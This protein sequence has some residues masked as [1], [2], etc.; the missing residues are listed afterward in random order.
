MH[1]RHPLGLTWLLSVLVLAACA[2]GSGSSGFD[3][4]PSAEN[5][6]ISQAL[7][8]QRCVQRPALIICPADQ[9]TPSPLPT[10]TAPGA[11]TGT[12]VASPTPTVHE[13][14]VTPQ[15]R[16][17]T[18]G[19]D[20]SGGVDCA[21]SP[22]DNTCRFTLPFAPQGFPLTAMVRI[23]VRTDETGRWTISSAGPPNGPLAMPSFDAPVAVGQAVG[24]GVPVQIAILVF[25]DFPAAI[26]A[27][28][29]ELAESG[30]DYAFVTP[31]ISVRPAATGAR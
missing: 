9:E 21:P 27:E 22:V 28:V 15:P 17:D 30:A 10:P 2:G 4:S 1:A 14:T 8:Q 19:I 29:T 20:Q 5:A 23:A 16:V 13:P 25:L 7:D 31:E 26:P 12:P 18:G 11:A 24:T 3:N 6:A